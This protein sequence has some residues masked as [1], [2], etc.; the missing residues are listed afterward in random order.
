MA[1]DAGRIYRERGGEYCGPR[2]K[3]QRSLRKWTREDWRTE[4]GERACRDGA[5]DRY[6]PAKAWKMLTPAQRKATRQKKKAGKSQFVPNTKA[7]KAAGR[8]ARRQ[9]GDAPS[10]GASSTNWTP[11]IIGGVIIGVLIMASSE[12]VQETVKKIAFGAGDPTDKRIAKLASKLQPIARQFVESARAAG[13]RVV[14]TDGTRTVGEQNEIYAQG[15]TKPGKIVSNAKGGESAHNFGLAFDFAFGDALGRPTWPENAPWA[16][17]AA[18]G[19]ALGLEWG[20]DWKSFKDRP[21]LEMPEWRA[22][23]NAWRQSGDADYAI[24]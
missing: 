5:C 7:A 16:E 15:R 23:R 2:T 11:V 24:V 14:I 10:S 3:S 4:T 18:Y 12:K 1:Q 21:H 8:R 22:V 20:G 13:Y 17:A 19:K 6:L 9:L